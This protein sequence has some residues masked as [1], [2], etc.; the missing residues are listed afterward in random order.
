VNHALKNLDFLV[1][2]DIFLTET[3]LLADVVLPAASFAEKTGTY[4]NT[5]RRVQ[6]GYKAIEPPGEARAD[7]EIIC[8][9]SRRS[10]YDMKYS[11]AVE[12]LAEINSLTPSYTGITFDRLAASHGLQWPCPGIEHPGT[13]I[14]HKEKFTRGLGIFLPCGFKP[15]AEAPDEEY[16]FL[17]TTGRD[18]YQYHTGTMTRRT[19][20]LEREAPCALVQIN[21]DDAARLN[22]KKGDLVELASRRGTMTARADITEKVPGKVLFTTFH[23]HESPVNMLTNPALDPVSKI[24]EYKGCAVKIRRIS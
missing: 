6:A 21:T 8:E 22:I 7:W 15:L 24:P 10:G 5:E 14:L 12:I 9:I 4:T 18:Y 20:L 17:L 16:A 3:A 23:F 19:N 2:Q 11:S 13:P 1:V